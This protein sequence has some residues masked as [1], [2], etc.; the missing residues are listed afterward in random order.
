MW[1]NTNN[2]VVGGKFMEIFFIVI[3][4]I[5]VIIAFYEIKNLKDRNRDLEIRV[6]L[7][8]KDTGKEEFSTL[9]VSNDLKEKLLELKNNGEFVEAV[10][11]LRKSTTYDLL[12]A[13][14]YIDNLN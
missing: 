3:L 11:L 9:Y 14:E 5:A 7:L 2:K 6:N 4:I 13:K 8:L 10:K 1:Y 12:G